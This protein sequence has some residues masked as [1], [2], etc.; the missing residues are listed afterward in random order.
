M[1]PFVL[2]L[3]VCVFVGEV[4]GELLVFCCKHAMAVTY[5][6]LSPLCC[7]CVMLPFYPAGFQVADGGALCSCAY[8]FSVQ[9][10]QSSCVHVCC[11]HVKSCIERTWPSINN[12]RSVAR[13]PELPRLLRMAGHRLWERCSGVLSLRPQTAR[14]VKKKRL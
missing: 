10:R 2:C 1:L 3:C 6:S 12:Q 13:D 4:T 5:L 11:E 7:C 9:V 8:L 14:A